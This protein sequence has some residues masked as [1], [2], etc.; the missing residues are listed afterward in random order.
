MG[1]NMTQTVRAFTGAA[2]YPGVSLI[3]A[4]SPASPTASR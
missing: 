3:I 2:A 1:A 4:Y